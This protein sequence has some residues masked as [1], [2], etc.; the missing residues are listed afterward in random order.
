M[1]HFQPGAMQ[2]FKRRLGRLLS[3]G[4]NDGPPDL[5]ELWRDF[6]R[7]LSGLF[8]GGKGGAGGSGG[9]DT[10]PGLKGA[11]VG[12]S[13][14]GGLV[15]L[16]WLFSGFFTVQE[17]QQGVIT[18]FGKYSRTVDA[19]FQWRLPYPFQANEIVSVT[20]LQQ[21]D[22]GDT[23]IVPSTGL[24]D[25]SMLT[26]DENIVDI[27]FAVQYAVK[28]ARDYL[29]NN[30]GTPDIS[31]TLAAESA[32]REI[33]GRSKVDAVLYQQRDAI[34]AELVQ[35]IQTQ[36]DR[37]KAGIVVKSVNMRSVQPPEQ[38]QG[39]FEDAF[40]AGTDAETLKNQAQAYA[41]NVIPAAQ[42]DA[43]RLLAE[44]EGYKASVVA[45]AEGDAERFTSVLAEYKK[46]PGVTRDRIY[47]DTMRQIFK[48]V[49][50]V[51]VDSR[52]GSSL[53]YLPLDKL[54]QQSGA[55]AGA[56]PAAA[57]VTSVDPTVAGSGSD[58]SRGNDSRG[59][60]RDGR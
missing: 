23:S 14:V 25:S 51:M 3:N 49:T 27:Q 47:L 20:Q 8:G 35:S 4:R 42:G 48:S 21:V 6:N 57:A 59:R 38:V 54:L 56:A 40:K 30:A 39:A 44:A 13:L 53:L 60:D 16:I 5:D 46:A 41:N 37:L 9:N 34:A 22:V 55:S 45:T 50:K 10:P 52:N 11:G 24:R 17:G 15:V 36:L 32:V 26:E 28:D 19:G 31:V 1:N 12:A 18:T 33:V 7:R 43:A 29:F 2:G 58:R